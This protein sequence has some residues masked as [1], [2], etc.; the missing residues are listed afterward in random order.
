[1][2]ADSNANDTMWVNLLHLPRYVVSKDG[3]K[4]QSNRH[5]P[6]ISAG[7]SETISIAICSGAAFKTG[8]GAGPAER[9]F[10]A[11]DSR[12]AEAV[13]MDALAVYIA[14][15]WQKPPKYVEWRNYGAD[16]SSNPVNRYSIQR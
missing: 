9:K 1:M 16:L 4:G 11:Y 7:V 2:D 3:T 10:A 12:K 14:D 8:V 5:L 6:R 15:V 13:F